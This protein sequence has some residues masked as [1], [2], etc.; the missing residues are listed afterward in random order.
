M[1]NSIQDLLSYCSDIEFGPVGI[2]AAEC[3]FYQSFNDEIIS[4]CRSLPESIQIEAIN[5]CMKY[6]GIA[7]GEELNFFKYFYTPT[8]SI[9][10]WLN[11]SSQQ[12]RN[13][14]HVDIKHA[15]TI[16]ALAMYLHSLDDHLNDGE[17]PATHLILLIRSQ[18]WMRMN[19][20]TEY[21]CSQL[22]DGAKRSQTLLDEYY[23]TIGKSTEGGSLNQYCDLFKKQM[24]IGLIAP[25]LLMN[26][27]AAS[28]NFTDDMIT[29]YC[30][31]GIAWR[32]L[33]D[34]K[35]IK[36]DMDKST[37]S[38]VYVCLPRKMQH[39]WNQLKLTDLNQTEEKTNSVL[40]CIKNKN[41]IGC[42]KKRIC[43]ELEIAASIADRHDIPNFA[44]EFRSL[45][46][47]LLS[48]E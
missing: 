13:L 39:S 46:K 12:F 38:A 18:A 22:T 35:D 10:Y 28:Q 48:N 41:I 45:L 9:L 14:T 19:H 43:H 37:H 20:A 15:V 34:I 4:L 33:D 32:L 8:W 24:S 27:M 23:D 42:L 29:A 6:S 7:F 44:E 1:T 3:D 40:N 25:V 30:A 21:F 16:Q 47:P 11:E 2:S 36:I 31:F 17:V 26:R 5:F